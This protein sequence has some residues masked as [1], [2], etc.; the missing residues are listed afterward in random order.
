MIWFINKRELQIVETN[1]Y[2]LYKFKRYVVWSYFIN[3]ICLLQNV[4]SKNVF[5][6][7]VN[8]TTVSTAFEA[9]F[10]TRLTPQLLE[11]LQTWR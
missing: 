2:M 11:H 5:E 6:A 3:R 8:I 9:E 1:K 4:F 10:E 7:M